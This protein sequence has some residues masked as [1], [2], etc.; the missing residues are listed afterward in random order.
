MFDSSVNIG[1]VAGIRIGIH[2]T[3]IVIFALLLFSLTAVFH[4]SHPALTRGEVVVAAFFAAVAFFASIILHELGHSLV[5]LAHGIPVHSIT[6]FIFGGVAQSERD[7]ETARS[8]FLIAIAGPVVSLALAAVFFLL[9][10]IFGGDP[11]AATA[12][13]WLAEI[14]LIVAVFNLLPGFPLDGGRVLR[15]AIWG[16]TGDAVKGM[17]WA[18]VSG[19]VA[20]FGLMLIGVFEAVAGGEIVSGFWLVAIGWFL[21]AAAEASGRE[22]TVSRALRGV[23]VA[24]YMRHDVPRVEGG[25]SVLDWMDN[26]VLATGQ[27]AYLVTENGSALGLAT[28]SDAK[29]A[30]R[31]TWATTPVRAVMTPFEDLHLADPHTPVMTALGL[32]DRESLNQLP[33]VDN[34]EIVGWIDRDRLL[35]ALRLQ[36]EAKS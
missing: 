28:L 14:N 19:R 31:A 1:R 16:G 7:A 21:Y 11:L 13:G 3:W 5:A 8:E 18:V 26:E 30:P 32:M 6:L 2:Y 34:G 17:R 35:Q 25:R 4:D 33:V 10:R 24:R 22:F 27:R 12:L 9:G 23:T 20:A 29:K 15:A 36:L